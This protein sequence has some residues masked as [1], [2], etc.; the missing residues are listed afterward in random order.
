MWSVRAN[1]WPSPPGAR[2]LAS[3]RAW[4]PRL[5]SMPASLLCV[6]CHNEDAIVGA[7]ELVDKAGGRRFPLTTW[8]SSRCWAASPVPLSAW[9]ARRSRPGRRPNWQRAGELAGSDPVAYARLSACSKPSWPAADRARGPAATRD[10]DRIL[11]PHRHHGLTGLESRRCSVFLARFRWTICRRS[12][13]G[14]ARAVKACEW[15][16][17]TAGSTPP[18]RT[19][20]G[21]WTLTLVSSCPRRGR[22]R[23]GGTRARTTTPSGTV[24]R[25]RA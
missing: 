14:E 21:E 24:R 11:P 13:P 6:P 23:G 3:P 2:T 9:P 1:R 4:A 5:G 18:I 15:P 22:G 16:W 20:T 7:L 12:G 17:S 10:H 8:N 25:A 19:W